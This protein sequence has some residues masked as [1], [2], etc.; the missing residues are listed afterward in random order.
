MSR[1]IKFP[2]WGFNLRVMEVLEFIFNYFHFVCISVTLSSLTFAMF[3]TCIQHGSLLSLQLAFDSRFLSHS[4]DPNHALKSRLSHE[5]CYHGNDNWKICHLKMTIIFF[6]IKEPWLHNVYWK[7]LAIGRYTCWPWGFGLSILLARLFPCIKI[8]WQAFL[9]VW[10][11]LC[12][13]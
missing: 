11:A 9:L 13:F 6:L 5:T 10:W 3:W 7:A 1:E 12:F 2:K 4:W 8:V